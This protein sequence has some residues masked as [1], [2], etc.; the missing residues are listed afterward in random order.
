MRLGGPAEEAAEGGGNGE[1]DDDEAAQGGGGH[2]GGNQ[3]GDARVDQAPLGG[4]E[5][6][7]APPAARGKPSA[8]SSDV[9]EVSKPVEVIDLSDTES[10]ESA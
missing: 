2:A 9:D 8:S 3:A 5:A 7:N 4:G 1:G 6:G 10:I